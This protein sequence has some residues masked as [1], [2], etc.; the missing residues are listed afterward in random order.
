[1]TVL[2]TVGQ[3]LY[4]RIRR[5]S[6]R[7]RTIHPDLTDYQLKI[8]LLIAGGKTS[9]EIAALFNRSDKTID[10]IRQTIYSQT[11]A[12][13]VAELTIW[14]MKELAYDK[15]VQEFLKML[16]DAATPTSQ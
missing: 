11:N 3:I 7:L 9:K 10:T 16:Q 2:P 12:N 15:T 8:A 14:L 6:P 4:G 5:P 1:M 13:S